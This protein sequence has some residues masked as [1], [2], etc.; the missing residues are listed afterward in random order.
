MRK[1]KQALLCMYATATA[2]QA[3]RE[4]SPTRAERRSSR[5]CGR[6][7]RSIIRLVL[8][9]LLLSSEATTIAATSNGLTAWIWRRRRKAPGARYKSASVRILNRHGNCTQ[10]IEQ[11]LSM[12]M[13]CRKT[14]TGEK[15]LVLSEVPTNRL[16]SRT[17]MTSWPFPFT[18]DSKKCGA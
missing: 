16:T 12:D 2:L 15:K 13:R 3:T 18:G 10:V 11:S 7:W 9:S 14:H 1:S 6:R 17:I 4:S 5:L 8:Q